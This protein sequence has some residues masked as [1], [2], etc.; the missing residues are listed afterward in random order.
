MPISLITANSQ[1]GAPA[2]SAYYSNG[3]GTAITA[4]TWTKVTF[5]VEEFDTNN[6]F[7]SSRFTPTVAGYYQINGEVLT[8]GSAAQLDQIAI[9]KNGTI[10]KSNAIY[11]TSAIFPN[12]YLPIASVVY[13]NGSTD[14]IEIYTFSTV[15]GRGYY[16]STNGVLTYF[17]GCFVR[18]A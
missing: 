10:Y 2:F 3:S 11:G 17:N 5:D 12:C 14:Y 16:G 9:Y 7:A 13:C 18:S 6:N 15:S 1:G 8:A 4:S